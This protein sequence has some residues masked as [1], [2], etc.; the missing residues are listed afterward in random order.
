M[1]CRD[2]NGPTPMDEG[3]GSTQLTGTNPVFHGE[4]RQ[5]T[6]SCPLEV[7]ARPS[8]RGKADSGF[9]PI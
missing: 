4:R 6:R 5:R 9:R 2:A 7:L 8:A 1:E 3:G